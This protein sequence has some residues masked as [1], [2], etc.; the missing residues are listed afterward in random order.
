MLSN[1]LYFLLQGKFLLLLLSSSLSSQAQIV[2]DNTLPQNSVVN[3]DCNTSCQIDGGTRKGSNLFHSFKE[4]SVPENG[5]AVFNNSLKIENIFTRVTG[6]SI[7]NIDGA[8]RAQGSANLFLLNP[9]GIIFGAN[10]QLDIGGSFLATT[11]DSIFFEDNSKFSAT[12]LQSSP[13]LIV[14]VPVGLQFGEN[15]GEIVNKSQ[16]EEIDPFFSS[17]LPVGLKVDDGKSIA[18]IASG[19]TLDNGTITA[20]EGRIGLGSVAAN[21]FVNLTQDSEGLIFN[22]DSVNQFE[23]I[24]IFNQSN[25]TANTNISLPSG[26]IQI[27]GSIVELNNSKIDSLNGS[28]LNGKGISINSSETLTLQDTEINTGTSEEGKAGDIN[29]NANEIEIIREE[30]PS[31]L[32]SQTE[33]SSGKAGDLTINTN[34][35]TLKNGAQVT[36]S[37]FGAGDGGNLSVN[38]SE[39]IEVTGRTADGQFPSGIFSQSEGGNATGDAGNLQIATGKLIVR[40]GGRISVGAIESSNSVREGISQGNGGTLSLKATESVEIKGFGFDAGGKIVPSTLLS[41]SQ[42]IGDA[43]NITIDTPQLIVTNRGEVNVSA[44]GTGAAGSLNIKSQDITLD[45]G[46]LSAQTNAGRQGNITI[47]DADTLLLRNNSEIT[48]NA[49]NNATGGNI[50]ITS[51]GIALL[52]NS[53]ITANAE[54]GR[55]GNI[56]ITTERLFQEPNSFITAFSDRNIDGIVIIES[57]DLDPSSGIFELGDIPVDISKIFDQNLCQLKDGKIA[58]G[59]KFIITGRGGITPTSTEPLDNLDRVVDWANR[60]DLQISQ[61]G[62][63]GVRQRSVSNTP[64]N[65]YPVIQQSQG[66]VTASDGS[67]WLVTNPP[68]TILQNSRLAHPD[69]R[70]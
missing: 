28:Y 49:Q 45:R 6:S 68:E 44:I 11:A 29:V 52:N 19:I 21:S 4:F 59:S 50:N 15:P 33:A 12:N 64:E 60:D 16:F 67:I 46:I 3:P 65:N 47:N 14:S 8:I 10:A 32:F 35:L 26:T 24:S 55:G 25:L 2:P 40:D 1:K 62:I 36:V 54:D 9:N 38:A 5:A 23:K 41:E 42:G 13:L 56:Q 63:V 61:N 57:P 18:L 39:V 43:G 48:T 37:T 66:W 30:S 69:C 70:S 31:G 51:A 58:G 17:L 53:N 20:N 27:Y 22:Y 34:R 7:S